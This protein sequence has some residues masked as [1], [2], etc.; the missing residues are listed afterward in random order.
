MQVKGK[1]SWK[2]EL[3]GASLRNQP[4]RPACAS[5]PAPM[6]RLQPG[7]VPATC[8]TASRADAADQARNGPYCSPVQLRSQ[9][10]MVCPGA[11]RWQP[12][13]C[14]QQPARSLHQSVPAVHG[15]VQRRS[16]RIQCSTPHK[17][18]QRCL[19]IHVLEG[20]AVWALGTTWIRV[21]RR[22][23]AGADGGSA[24]GCG[25][26]RRVQ[27]GYVKRQRIGGLQAARRKVSFAAH[28]TLN[29]VRRF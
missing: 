6:G 19:A 7:C 3:L 5:N 8:A 4:S 11:D 21:G 10:V 15:C 13:D 18:W 28:G 20:S 22:R 12:A 27:A 14:L 1:G 2:E 24:A 16:Q 23:A 29:E 17:R 25:G 26:G 9:A